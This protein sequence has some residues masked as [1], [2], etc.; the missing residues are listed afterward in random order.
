MSHEYS[1][2]IARTEL[3]F[4]RSGFLI[5]GG[6]VIKDSTYATERVQ[7]LPINY[8]IAPQEQVSQ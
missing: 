5:A 4:K 3:A 1:Y 7:T 2:N 6:A 8:S